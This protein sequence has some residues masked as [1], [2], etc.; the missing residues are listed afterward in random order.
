MGRHKI[1]T[2]DR[3]VAISTT[4][5]AA[6]IHAVDRAAEELSMPRSAIIELALYF[7]FKTQKEDKINARK[8]AP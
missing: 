1:P 8:P 7:Y 5:P 4:L 2:T 6:M 3:R